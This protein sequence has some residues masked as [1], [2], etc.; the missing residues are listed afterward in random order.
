M[1]QPQSILVL[2]VE[3]EPLIRDMLQAALEDG[4]FGVALAFS[5]EEALAK[6]GDEELGPRA[7]VTDIRLAPGKA[8]GWDVARRARELKPDLPVVYMTGD[9]SAEWASQGV[10]NSILVAKP[11]APAQ[12]IA[13]LSQLLNA[14]S[15]TAAPSPRELG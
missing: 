4:G 11:F 12:I 10:P 6:L 13:A 5:G 2:V 1:M 14:V 8:S 15:T 9:S 7:L 3:D